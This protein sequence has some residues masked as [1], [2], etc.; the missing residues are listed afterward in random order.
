MTQGTHFANALIDSFPAS[1][2]IF[3]STLSMHTVITAVGMLN[4][5]SG[6]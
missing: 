2:L 1:K 4:L 5:L 3:M 6:V